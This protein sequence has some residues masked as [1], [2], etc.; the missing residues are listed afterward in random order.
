MKMLH[1]NLITT[2]KGK[3][4]KTFLSII[5]TACCISAYSQKTDKVKLKNGDTITGEIKNMKLGRLSYDV[6]GPGVISIKWEEITKVTSDKV[7]E[8]SIIGGELYVTRIDSLFITHRIDTL[9][10][11]VEIIPVKDK[12]WSRLSG[13]VNM[14]FN[15]T[16]SNS[17]LQFNLSS[18]TYYKVPKFEANLKLNS[19]ITS[20]DND[21]T[22]SK[23][24]DA[25]LSLLR[26]MGKKFYWG[27]AAGWQQNT[28]L[29]ISNRYLLNGV[30]GWKAVADN[31]NRLLFSGG[32]S[33]NQE[34]SIETGIYDGYLDGLIRASYKRFY[35]STPKLSLD[36]DYTVYPG[37]TQ[38]GRVRMQGD[39]NISVEIFKDFNIGTQFYYSY[40]NR[41]PAGSLSNDDYGLVFTLGYSFN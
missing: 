26:N 2:V 24:Q 7:F 25:I 20:N 27:G 32:L 4:S 31:H 17:N 5:L 6:D 19:L 38:S 12:F 22:V 13:T 34:Q 15:Y 28:E 10:Q 9:D 8:I 40:D 41:P 30:L 29:G 23:K 35:Y 33:Y 18:Y 16:K 3:C 37:I 21:S 1:K 39:L 14:G 36:A 11:I